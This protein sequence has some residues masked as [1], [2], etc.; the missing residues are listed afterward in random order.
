MLGVQIPLG[1]DTHPG[2][3]LG[4]EMKPTLVGLFKNVGE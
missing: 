1:R 4:V 2:W 3:V